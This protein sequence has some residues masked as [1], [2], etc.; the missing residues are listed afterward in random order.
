MK[1]TFVVLALMLFVGSVSTTVFA[2]VN[3]NDTEITK[4]DDDK[5]KKRN[6]KA[7]KGSCCAAKSGE[8][9]TSCGTAEKKTCN[10]EKK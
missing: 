1:K 7:K 10:T 3:G 2:S 4:K 8:A 5:K 9:K 6:K